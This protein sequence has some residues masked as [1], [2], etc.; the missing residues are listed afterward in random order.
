MKALIQ[1]L[2][3]AVILFTV[4]FFIA[5]AGLALIFMGVS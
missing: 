2:G 5:W 4:W 1:I 3:C